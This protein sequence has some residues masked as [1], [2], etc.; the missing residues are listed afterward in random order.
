MADKATKNAPFRYD[1][2]GSFLRPEAI[3][4]ARA[5]FAAERSPRRRWKK[6]RMKK[7]K[8]WWKKRRRRAFWA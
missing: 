1:I 8:S 2:V 6:L 3:Q 4:A 5:R 7:S